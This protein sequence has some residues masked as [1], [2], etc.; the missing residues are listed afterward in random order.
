MRQEDEEAWEGRKK[1]GKRR[2]F[3]RLPP[4]SLDNI[5]ITQADV[6]TSGRAEE[7]C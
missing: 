3:D 5:K 7:R 1:A 2:G 4:G 6:E